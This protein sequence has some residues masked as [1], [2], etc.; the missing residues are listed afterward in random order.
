MTRRI[1]FRAGPR[2]TWV[3]IGA[4]AGGLLSGCTRT[5]DVRGIVTY[6]QKSL[7]F[8]NVKMIAS[9]GIPRDAWIASNGHYE[10]LGIPQ[11]PAK[12]AVYCTPPEMDDATLQSAGRD[13]SG[14]S[15]ESEEL[16]R[17]PNE[18]LLIPE[19]YT[20]FST[21]GLRTDIVP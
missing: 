18:W 17:E 8:G 9:D 15:L 7:E 6:Q 19:K 2:R 16:R 20:G 12:F 13:Q 21:S 5:G 10:F 3:F 14:R 1:A 4:I 11:G